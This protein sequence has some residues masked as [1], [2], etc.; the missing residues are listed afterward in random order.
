MRLPVRK[1][2]GGVLTG[3]RNWPA[4]SPNASPLSLAKPGFA[5]GWQ[6][7]CAAPLRR[8]AGQSACPGWL[9]GMVAPMQGERNAP[10]ERHA[11]RSDPAESSRLPAREK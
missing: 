2:R 4:P 8:Q 6:G 11:G 10:G 9:H 7:R 5:A 1:A 3:N